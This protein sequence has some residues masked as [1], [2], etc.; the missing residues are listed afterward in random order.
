MKHRRRT[1]IVAIAAIAAFAAICLIVIA[2]PGPRAAT[3]RTALSLFLLTKSLHLTHGELAIDKNEI[4]ARDLVITNAAGDP[5][6]S[7][8]EVTV[9]YALAGGAFNISAL[10][11]DQPHI[12]VSREPGGSFDL[13]ND[14]S[15][16][17]PGGQ[18]GKPLHMDIEVRD[19]ELDVVN[20]HSPAKAGRFVSIRRIN[21]GMFVRQGAFSRGDATAVVAAGD[22]T[23]PV[24]ANFAENDTTKIARAAIH[25]S[26]APLAPVVDLLTSTR[27]FV[28]ESGSADIAA[29]LFAIDW[30]TST[31]P[32]WHL[33]GGG[34]IHR[35]CLRTLPIAV[36]ICGVDGPF[37]LSDGLVIFPKLAA[38]ASGI[39]LSASG[40]LGFSP[41]P[42]VGLSLRARA[43]LSRLRTLL[44]FSR[45]MPLHGSAQLDA[46]LRGPV[47]NPHAEITIRSIRALA[48]GKVPVTSLVSHLYYHDGHVAILSTNAEYDHAAIYA[49]GDIDLTT[50]PVSGQFASMVK[51]AAG[52]LPV[53]AQLNPGAT[54]RFEAAFTGPLSQLAGA[55]FADIRGGNTAG[56]TIRAALQTTQA[57]ES[58]AVLA[59][60][61]HGGDLFA[62]ARTGRSASDELDADVIARN[63][64]V[65][66]NGSP[67]SLPGI[68][69]HAI[70]VPRSYA[71]L[72]G[73]ASASGTRAHPSGSV[74]MTASHIDVGEVGG[75]PTGV[76]G[77]DS[78][79]LRGIAGDG[80]WIGDVI[81]RGTRMRIGG[82]STPSVRG[83]A[84]GSGA[85][86]ESGDLLAQIGGGQVVV[87]GSP[88]AQHPGDLKIYLSNVDGSALRS[89]GVPLAAGKLTAIA[90][91]AGTLQ[92]PAWLVRA[93]ISNGIIAGHAVSADGILRY[94]GNSIRTSGARMSLDGNVAYIDGSARIAGHG[95]AGSPALDANVNIPVADLGALSAFAGNSSSDVTGVASA[96]MHVGG[97]LT[98]PQFAGDVGADVGTVRGVTYQHLYAHASGGP[99]AV[100]IQD[101]G[102]QFGGSTLQVAGAVS[103]SSMALHIAGPHVDLDDFNDFFNG[104]DVFDGHGSLALD[105]ASSSRV[106]RATGYMRL[107]D[108]R[109]RGVPLGSV[110]AAFSPRDGRTSANIVQRGELGSANLRAD[111]AL[112]R[113]LTSLSDFNTTTYA[114]QGTIRA[115]SL[116]AIAPFVGAEDQ[117]ID[118][119]LTAS[120]Q[121]HGPLHALQGAATLNLVRAHVRGVAIDSVTAEVRADRKMVHL[122]SLR[123]AGET[124]QVTANGRLDKSTGSMH[125]NAHATIGDLGAIARLVRIPGSA[126]G[127]A[128]IDVAA[129]GTTA[130]PAI[131]ARASA[132]RGRLHDFDF[133]SASLTAAYSHDD[134]GVNGL[135]AL[136]RHGG[137][138]EAAANIPVRLQPFGIGPNSADVHLTAR[139]S[140]LDLGAIDPLL[141]NAMSVHGNLDA[142]VAVTG[143]VGEPVVAGSAQLR[144]ASL[145]SKYD[146]VGAHGV[147]ADVAFA[148]DTIS[149]R[150]FRS[151]LGD[152][153]LLAH[154]DAHIVPATRMH[155]APSL[156]F[157]MRASMNNAQFDVPNLVKG[158][159]TG[160]LSLTKS[161]RVPYLSG[162]VS[163]NKTSIPFA[164]ILALASGG[165][166]A[167][168]RTGVDI[169]GVPKPLPGRFVGYAGSI[170]G[171][172]DLKLVTQEP[173][174]RRTNHGLLPH[175]VDLGLNVRAGN[176]VGLT[177]AISAQG[178]GTLA[179]GGSTR[180]PKVAGT[181]T[182][183]RGRAGFLNTRFDLNYGTVTFDPADGLLP[184]LD[185]E[186]TTSTDT[187]DITVTISGRVDQLHTDFS[188]NPEMPSDA[189]VASILH[190][191]Q[192]NSALASSHG[193]EQSQFGVAPQDVVTGAI[194]GQVLGALNTGLEQVLNL[195]EVNLQMDPSGQPELEVRKQ[196]GPHAYTIYKSTFSVPPAQV[197]G[198]AYDVRQ[199]LQVEFTQSQ[200]TPGTSPS[201]APPQTSLEVQVSFH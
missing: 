68:S 13:A 44:A 36:A 184:T 141:A 120:L 111:V 103:P 181:L 27:A 34:A 114:L 153:T 78:L 2:A 24:R 33:T 6:I 8:R 47:S 157:A 135:L 35:A 174:H 152:G 88:P 96:K 83:I 176:D 166:T 55:G 32:A 191:P 49:N 31:G 163:L 147:S 46:A 172:S 84:V 72:D 41:E 3:A 175:K 21:A 43:P 69:T 100:D 54:A 107:R 194:A 150:N 56:V 201:L 109:V 187:A 45:S 80:Q 138:V 18:S 58:F 106:D 127:S 104:K 16:G 124:M 65:R 179:V 177:G 130:R 23:S 86:V 75:R 30:D 192:I 10:R 159:L 183:V 178:T 146:R 198:V 155:P 64:A 167:E 156:Q 101:A 85:R 195:G 37:A 132:G 71:S 154:G 151:Q 66:T 61:G 199:A 26:N 126:H 180:A 113:S 62:G 28:V 99:N 81:A 112:P 121:A 123:A 29:D 57:Q 188:S 98:A 148:G 197:F 9:R 136:A 79:S 142:G 89:F 139:A 52:R 108:V 70:G 161:G 77:V 42:A 59:E 143:T 48:Y 137:T 182:A 165:G 169:P 117:R 94:D 196:F 5:V 63:F 87:A 90:S 129:G 82:V 40:T 74:A 200:S 189:I 97:S 193:V 76:A 91:L 185:A 133:D 145:T 190:I 95:L 125:A 67:V 60:D 158:A 53:L 119:A 144:G 128:V 102:V 170:Y 39:S 17:G 25:L 38:T 118:G 110:D 4:E 162:D 122:Q 140:K 51:V 105:V 73:V 14:F 1:L 93:A 19:G 134:L 186:A 20:T 149:L 116:G 50:S 92:R 160:Q 131:T 168:P 22:A 173:A 115:P 171:S 11:V 12:V 7:A 164:A 15:P